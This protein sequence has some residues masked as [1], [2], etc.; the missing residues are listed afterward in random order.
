LDGYLSSPGVDSRPTEILDYDDFGYNYD[1]RN[2]DD[3]DEAYEDNYAPLFFGVFM[4]DNEIAEQ[5]QPREV[6]EQR[7]RQEAERR[8]LE[9]E[10][11]A[12]ERD[13]LQ[14][15]QQEREWAAKEAE[16]R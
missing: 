1:L 12:Q 7:T 14:R 13:R 16:D 3:S 4:A 8:R 6:E 11:Q 10:R 2:L 15:E 5:R 9:E